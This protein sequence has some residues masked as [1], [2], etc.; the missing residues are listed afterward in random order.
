MRSERIIMPKG[1]S[2]RDRERRRARILDLVRERPIRSQQ[3][4]AGLLGGRLAVN[5]ATLSR[6]LRHMGLV[7]GPAGYELP[8]STAPAGDDA[9]VGLVQA[10]R[11]WL[12]TVAI[13]QNLLVLKTPPGGASPL[14]VA[15][16]RAAPQGMLGSVAGDDTILAVC[17]NASSARAL[18]RE[19]ER[20][21]ETPR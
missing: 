10:V 1:E 17:G 15:L 16:D 3:E 13:A 5:Q 7:K 9:A 19:L 20:T 12:S 14:A 21:R 18:A 6:D 4:L 11:Q 8:R 2:H